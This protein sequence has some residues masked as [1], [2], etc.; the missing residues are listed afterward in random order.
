MPKK[1]IYCSVR[2]S[3]TR[4]PGTQVVPN[5]KKYTRKR[6]KEV[7]RKEKDLS[8]DDDRPFSF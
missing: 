6:D 2:R 1:T 4:K 7:L 5:K 8:G 3:W